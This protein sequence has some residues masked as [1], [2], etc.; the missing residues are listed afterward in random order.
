MEIFGVHLCQDEL[1]PLMAA[2]PAI[3]VGWYKVKAFFSA[4]ASHDHASCDHS[5][6]PPAELETGE[7]KK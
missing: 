6:V 5:H 1:V 2:V 7:E 4:R 3:S